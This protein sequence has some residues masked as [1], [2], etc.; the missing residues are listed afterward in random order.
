[1]NYKVIE[2]DGIRRSK[3]DY[4]VDLVKKFDNLLKKA[5]DLENMG[6][7]FVEIHNKKYCLE[8]IKV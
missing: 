7:C 1:M 2:S 4:S 8:L 5:N 6:A 3:K